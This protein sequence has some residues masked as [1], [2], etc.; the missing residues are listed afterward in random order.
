MTVEQR[1]HGGL[2]R[3]LAALIP[4]TAPDAS[5]SHPQPAEIPLSRIR[6]NPFQPRT[7][8]EE[9]DLR[10]LADSVAIHGVIQPV[11]VVAVD[12]GYQLIAG[13]RRVRAAE[14]AGLTAVPAVVRT[15]DEQAQLALA[16]V[17]NLQRS[18]LNAMDEARAFRQL[19][20]DFGLTQEE[21]A[22]RIGRSRS[23]IA[24]TVRLLS[25]SARVQ[26]SVQAGR[27]SEGH[28]RTLAALDDHAAQDLALALVE[29]RGLSV[30]QTED[31]V[32]QMAAGPLAQ[33]ATA[34]QAPADPDIERME[35]TLRDALGTKVTLTP[36]RRGGRITIAWYDDED[37]GRLFD[38]LTGPA[39]GDR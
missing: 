9:D 12:G 2:G 16:L 36:G 21:V 38:R 39:G 32:R 37:L 23:A 20:T 15:A 35:A 29:E 7:R 6:R 18:D 8:F 27:I 24:N 1:R 4:T 11:L 30:R 10:A 28:A 22:R 31:L 3:G 19:M 17:E 34:A 26:D 13:E 25:A 5:A 14:L 33:P